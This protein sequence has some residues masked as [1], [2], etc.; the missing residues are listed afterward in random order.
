MGLSATSAALLGQLAW[1]EQTTYELGKAMGTNVR[2]FWPRAESHVYREVK[3]LTA[4]GFATAARGA[5]GRRPHTTY[6]ITAAG[7]AALGN[8]LA[9]AP[10]GVALEHEPLLRVFLASNG[11]RADLLAAIRAARDQAQAML[12]IGDGIADQYIA[13]DHPFQ[14]EVHIRAL[15]FD[16]LYNW[17]RF[18]AEWA[19][20]AESEVSGWRDVRSGPVKRRRAVRRVRDIV[21]RAHPSRGMARGGDSP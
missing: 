10:G 12:A 4:A 8:W 14:E 11:S 1:R 15:S 17:A 5:T 2:F 7:R 19:D 18:T 21:G 3:R 13:G 6:R 9:G 20:R 16:Y